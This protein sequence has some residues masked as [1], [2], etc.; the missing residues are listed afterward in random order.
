MRLLVTRPQPDAARTADALAA[1]GHVAIVS[2][3]L[4]FRP[5][6]ATRLPKRDFQA[7]I[8]TSANGVRAYEAHPE[9]TLYAG[10]PAFA[11]GD[12]TA[13]MA[14]RAGFDPVRSAGGDAA[15]LVRTVADALPRAGGPLLHIAGADQAGDLDASLSALGFALS[16]CVL[17]R[18]SPAEALA[19]PAKEA[20][21]EGALDGLLVYSPRSAAALALLLR[22][23]GL[24][25]LP[26]S[27]TAFCI[28]DAAARPIVP[29]VGGTVRIAA[30]PTQLDLFALLPP[31]VEDLT[32]II[33]H[34][35]E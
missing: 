22:R 13:V 2:P 3:V 9:R 33:S 29:L 8:F 30:A 5:D 10:R 1:L 16:A 34:M 6:G 15:A 21:A 32:P 4:E 17:Y 7:L 27:V 25:P 26:R 19:P 35:T 28:S 20:L 12:Y 11:V 23:A 18:M 14:R 31:G 24:A